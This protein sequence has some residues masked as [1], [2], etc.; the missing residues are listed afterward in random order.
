[1]TKNPFLAKRQVIELHLEGQ[2]QGWQR[3]RFQGS[4]AF[5]GK[6]HALGISEVRRAWEE[7]GKPRLPE[8]VAIGIEVVVGVERP[9]SH[10][11]SKN[12]LNA[13]GKRHPIPRNKKP[14]LDNV[15]KLI[16]DALNSR[17]Y[18]DDVMISEMII[19]RQ[20]SEWPETTIRLYPL[21]D[22]GE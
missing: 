8:D 12:E 16:C 14:D 15:C 2:A 20:W 9:K 18:R 1:M 19:K 7:A 13:T 11:N 17:A 22:A 5:T 10:F 21:H 4:R 3:P 6:K